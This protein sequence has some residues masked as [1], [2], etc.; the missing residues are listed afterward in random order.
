M[1]WDQDDGKL[2]A[3]D[4]R[5]TV[6]PIRDGLWRAEDWVYAHRGPVFSPAFASAEEAQG[7]CRA[8]LNTIPTVRA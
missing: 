2:Y 3:C 5:F 1:E 8:R 7:W 4:D 6:Y